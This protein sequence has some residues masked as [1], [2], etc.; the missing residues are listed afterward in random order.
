M[1]WACVM[2]FALDLDRSNL[3]SANSDNFLNDLKLT[4]NDFNL[5]NTLFR[6]AFLCAGTY[7]VFPANWSFDNAV[8]PE[9]PS[10]LISKRVG[11]DVWVPNQARTHITSWILSYATYAVLRSYYGVLFP[12]RNFGCLVAPA[13]WYAGT[14][15]SLVWHHSVLNNSRFLLGFLQGG[16]IPDIVLYLSYFYTGHE[17][18]SMVALIQRLSWR[19]HSPRPPRIF[20]AVKL[21]VS[22]RWCL[23]CHWHLTA[24]W[25]I[26]EG[27]MAISLSP[28]G[29]LDS[30]SGDHF[31]F[32]HARW[33]NAN[34]NMVSS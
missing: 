15:D 5:G 25:C 3:S 30:T 12:C 7:P 29:Y 4:T 28:R 20:L 19:A 13:S 10:Q 26:W 14:F 32:L 16:F 18:R 22:Y 8:V 27:R 6:V 23:S 21:H 33:A 11:P 1:V 24:S 31:L 2:F 34:E 17:R 9:L